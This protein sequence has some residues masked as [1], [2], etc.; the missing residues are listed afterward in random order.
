MPIYYF[1]GPIYFFFPHVLVSKTTGVL[2][3]PR[4]I[5]SHI[6]VRTVVNIRYN[7]FTSTLKGLAK[8]GGVTSLYRGAPWRLFRQICGIFILDKARV[9]LSPLLFPDR[10][11]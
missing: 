5:A 10:F 6:T 1:S 9:T 7:T 11:K 3:P 2:V 8:E 4:K